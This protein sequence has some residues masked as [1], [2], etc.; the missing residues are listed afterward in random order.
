M[1]AV[2]Q[3]DRRRPAGDPDRKVGRIV[4]SRRAAGP[5]RRFSSSNG[6]L[7]LARGAPVARWRDG[8]LRLPAPGVRGARAAADRGLRAR[9][10]VLRLRRPPPRCPRPRARRTLH[11]RSGHRVA[12]RL[13]VADR[14]RH[15]PA[16]AYRAAAGDDG[17]ERPRGEPSG[18]DDRLRAPPGLSRASPRR[19]RRT[20][21]TWGVS[22]ASCRRP[23]RSPPTGTT[24][25]SRLE[26][27][28]STGP[29]SRALSVQ[30]RS[31]P[32]SLDLRA[33]A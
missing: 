7:R 1:R 17:G 8:G 4:G 32:L 3:S 18:G 15:R 29:D 23:R 13:R 6:S 9:G 5:Q 11:R 33:P 21:T 19:S 12:Q 2:S 22:A 20:G 24:A 31:R 27:P 30:D 26:S 10:A 25:C 16:R 14:R 28:P